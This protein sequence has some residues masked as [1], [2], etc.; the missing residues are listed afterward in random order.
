MTAK[1]KDD[2]AEQPPAEPK[3][4]GQADDEPCPVCGLRRG[5]RCGH[6]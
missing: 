6:V 4:K 5:G 1:K 2:D 3:S